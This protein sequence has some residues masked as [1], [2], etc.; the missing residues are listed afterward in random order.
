[1]SAPAV[2]RGFPASLLQRRL[3]ALAARNGSGRSGAALRLDL[4]RASE[5]ARVERA[6]AALAGRHEILRTRLV[7]LAG[8]AEPLQVIA[9]PG[10]LAIPFEVWSDASMADPDAL[11]RAL[12]ERAGDAPLAAALVPAAAGAPLLLVSLPASSA[13]EASFQVLAAELE[14]ELAG[15]PADGEPMQYADF[16]AWHNDVAL[17]ADAERDAE[18]FVGLDLPALLAARLPG[19][20]PAAGDF[21]PRAVELER[22]P[23]DLEAASRLAAAANVAVE[24]ALLAAW[25]AL[26]WRLSG[27]PRIAVWARVAGR[28]FA[29]LEMA[30]GA[31]AR[32]LPVVLEPAEAETLPA[33]ARRTAGDL[34]GALP[35]AEGF[36]WSRIAA[37]AS[38]T[39]EELGPAWSFDARRPRRAGKV[40]ILARRLAGER[41]TV[42]LAFPA[43]A[44]AAPL[45]IRFDPAR[46]DE[47]EARRLAGRWLALVRGAAE[48]PRAPLAELPMLAAAE[49]AELLVERNATAADFGPE[50]RLHQLFAARA[51][52]APF[53]PAVRCGGV[54]WTRGELAAAARRV[55]FRLHQAGVGPEVP[56]GLVAE[57]SLEMV[58]G[59][60]GI[61]AAGG[62]FVPVDPEHPAGRVADV[63][64]ASGARLVL[65]PERH[66]RAGTLPAISFEEALAGPESEGTT[67]E[68]DLENTAYVLF[69]SGSTGRPKGVAVSHGAIANRV[70]WTLAE[71]PLDAG[72][73]LLQKTPLT[74]DASLWEVF[75]PLCAGALLVLALPGEERDTGLLVR[76]VASEEVT[77]LQLVP[78]LLRPF[79]DE[80]AIDGCRALRRLHCGGEALAADLVRRFQDLFPRAEVINLYGPTE[81]AIDAVSH[82]CEPGFART[83]VP[84][85]RPIANLA[86]WVVS[87]AL[88]AVPAGAP[89]ELLLAGAGL[90]RGYAGRP[91]L[92]A[93][94]FVPNPF[95]AEAG[96]AGD[97]AYR[98]GD[99]A[100]W[101]PGGE[102]EVLG[103]ADRQVKIR[104]V[105]IEPAEIEARLLE[106]PAVAQAVVVV[107]EERGGKE[108]VGYVVPRAEADAGVIDGLRAFL[109]ARLPAALVP[110]AIVA[111]AAFP[112]TA[113]GKLDLAALP[114][115]RPA[116]EASAAD[117]RTPAEE[118]LAGLFAEVLGRERVGARESFFDLGGHSLSA[119]QLISRA[120]RAFGVELR[121]HQL[122]DAPTVAG[123]AREVERAQAGAAGTDAPP[124]ERVARDGR[125]MRLPLSFAQQRLWF[126]EQLRPGTA[127]FNIPDAVRLRGALDAAALAAAL[128]GVVARHE[129]LR[130]VFPALRGE[131]VQEIRPAAPQPLPVVDLAGLPSAAREAELARL[132]AGE[133]ALPLDLARGP[134]LRTRLLRFSATDHVLT[135]TIHHIASDAWSSGIFVRDL[136]RLY[137]AALSG[138]PRPLPPL[139]FQYADFAA[140]QRRFLSGATLERELDWW[141]ERLAGAPPRLD[142]PSDRPRPA[143]PS[144]RGATRTVLL[145]LQAADGLRAVA[146]EEGVTLFMALT[147][148]WL[149]VAG[150]L[151][152]RDDLVIGTDVANRNRE[153]TEGIVGFFINQLALRVRL[154][155]DPTFRELVGRVR[156]VA[157]G[158]YAHQD[159]PFDA[160]V[161]ALE[162]DRTVAHAP[163]FQVKLFLENASRPA[164]PVP[165][166]RIE[167]LDVDIRIAKLDLVLAFWERP[168]GLSGW[169]NYSTDL[170][171][172]P[173]V[174]RWL[175]Q[176]ATLAGRAALAPDTRLSAL[177]EALAEIEREELAMEKKGLRDFS[178]RSFRSVQPKPVAIAETEVVARGYLAPDQTLPLVITPAVPDVDLAEWSAAHA[179]EVEADLV[180]HGA[181][182]FRGFGIDTPE[183]L[184]RFANTLCKELFNENGEHPRESVSGNV[185]TPVFYPQ[186]QRLLWH[187]ENSFNWRWP[188]KIF[189]ACARPAEQGGETPLVDSRRVYRELPDEIRAP[190]E[191]KGVMYQR[192]YSAGLG[193]PWQ[194]VFQTTDRAEVE[195]E[196][197][198][199]RVE[200]DWR[201]GDRL[202]TRGVR[203]AAIRHPQTG[204]PAW[205]NQGQH[206]HVGCLDPWTGKSMR[207]LFSDDDLPRHLLYGDGSP[208]PDEHMQ[209]ILDV[210]ARLEVV[211]PWQKGDVVLVDN[212]LVAHGRNPFRGERKIL[213][214]LGDMACYDDVRSEA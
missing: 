73:R 118:I 134:L 48:R 204:E 10:E 143:R 84:L 174:E 186:D 47:G 100:R 101:N 86:A 190:F 117:A 126:L 159:V 107:R 6:L 27:E 195:Q 181:I 172:A 68:V 200:I 53:E 13:D 147:A 210:Y 29:E 173:R 71:H 132:L 188:R 99:L 78:S 193:L 72:D 89:G 208:I 142:L 170:F 120:R 168:E 26:L 88:E 211:F 60:L 90:A 22:S 145:P 176:L 111:L 167:P 82:R 194:T 24:D 9:E 135:L 179:A 137:A 178:L 58:A 146:R 80:P 115:P 184:E 70:L 96:R 163:L 49:R 192:T 61:L 144:D 209:A 34:A 112:R 43:G 45:E 187:N 125:M 110:G 148:A 85:G 75:A 213:V 57:R 46:L 189:F 44:A 109:A 128:S 191:A 20:R 171:D 133:A 81:A 69:T 104:G 121:V 56:V 149:A 102:L 54:T 18:S 175:R 14:R 4:P 212:V 183:A 79:L 165:G 63:L 156:E 123:L 5:A 139:P 166:L 94:R 151:T 130:T 35:R 177:G 50:R 15:L 92:T 95:A 158:A 169:V 65:G 197:A 17:A 119:T 207:E 150:H 157:L 7:R 180:A 114:P 98:T 105:R 131:A 164:S 77:V 93:E 19:E 140:W 106:H 141:R 25:A 12:E 67:A 160:V 214:A 55:A 3:D 206:W 203:P 1:M 83:V 23:A 59:L 138:E 136:G 41:F 74:F 124:F 42:E 155:G 2:V 52:A 37:A 39:A 161:D 21:A 205:F 28:D 196:A 11:L 8:M 51:S 108:L 129:A 64:A 66:L 62:C 116:A 153:E 103:R 113:S 198:E 154:A 87:P 40:S 162:L 152:G 30:L 76:R 38:L 36:S 97:R 127:A 31:F 185:Y 91:D 16:A 32:H 201:D 122:F 199:T 182:L 33:L 202:R